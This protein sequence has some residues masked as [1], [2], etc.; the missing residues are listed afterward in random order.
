ME[1]LQAVLQEKL[2]EVLDETFGSMAFLGVCEASAA[3]CATAGSLREAQLLVT[4]PVLMELHLATSEALLRQMAETLYNFDADQIEDHLIN[5]LLAEILNTL[6]GR[7]MTAL[8]PEQQTFAL[9][10]P[11]LASEEERLDDNPLFEAF[12]LAD[13]EP[14]I[15]RLQASGPQALL[16]LLQP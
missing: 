3:D 12:Y 8:L 11:E 10:L 4:E 2:T 7:L 16:N 9:S 1:R 6:A 13:D 15:V 5:D 14:V